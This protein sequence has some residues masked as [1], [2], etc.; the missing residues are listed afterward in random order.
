M[1]P[2]QY[3]AYKRSQIVGPFIN[4]RDLDA[5]DHTLTVGYTVERN[6]F[7]AYVMDDR[8]HVIVYDR[9][10]LLSHEWGEMMHAD[11]LRPSKRA[12]PDAT[13]EIFALLMRNT[14]EPITFL[15]FF[16]WD[17]DQVR[18]R[19]AMGDLKDKTHLDF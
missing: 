2:E 11:R 10:N 5:G 3:E 18:Q 4:I 9:N 19:A 15:G 17:S 7:H 8:I 16:N 1:T 13:N 6:D 14:G 12:Y